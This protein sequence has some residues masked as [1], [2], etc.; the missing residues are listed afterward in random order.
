M[1]ANSHQIGVVVDNDGH[2]GQ[3][4]GEV[5]GN[6]HAIP[7][8]HDRWS[9]CPTS[10]KLHRTRNAYAD[11]ANIANRATCLRQQTF[12]AVA[13]PSKYA[14]GA[15]GNRQLSSFFGENVAAEI[16]DGKAGVTSA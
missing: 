9:N 16:A 4:L 3:V 8:G 12:Q 1:F 15:F 13:C 5:L 6:G 10:G 11:T 14:I 2:T 7:P